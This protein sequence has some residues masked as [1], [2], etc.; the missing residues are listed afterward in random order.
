M[1]NNP[2]LPNSLE[3][4]DVGD[5]FHFSRIIDGLEVANFNLIRFV[6]KPGKESLLDQ[7]KVKEY[8]YIAKGQG[9]LK[10]NEKQIIANPGDLFYFQSQDTHKIKNLSTNDDMEI[11]SIWW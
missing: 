9:L 8:W 6:V 11:L 7:H 1:I 3:Q 10:L 5:F 4:T 2:I